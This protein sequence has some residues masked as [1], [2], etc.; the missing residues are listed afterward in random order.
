M[1]TIANPIYDSVFK[2]LMDDERILLAEKDGQLAEK[3]GQLKALV[4]MLVEAGHT[5]EAIA[6]SLN[7]DKETVKTLLPTQ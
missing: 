5:I 2:Y 4:K 6:E 1:L 7:V 3:D